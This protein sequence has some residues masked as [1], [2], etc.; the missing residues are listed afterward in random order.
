MNRIILMG[1]LGADF[2]VKAA[3]NSSVAKSRIAVRRDY[4]NAQTGEYDTDWFN[5][6]VFGKRAETAAQYFHKGQRILIEGKLRANTVENNGVKTTYYDI[7]VDDFDFVE[8]RDP[9]QAQQAPQATPQPYAQ[10]PQQY[11]PQ[12]YAQAP[13]AAPQ[14]APQQAPQQYS[15]AQNQYAPQTAPQQYTQAPQQ[16]APQPYA[17]APQAAPQQAPQQAPQAAPAPNPAQGFAPVADNN[18]GYSIPDFSG[19]ELPFN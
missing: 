11:A 14:P 19:D 18:A 2:E 16:Y 3:G 4:K 6:S 1:T 15:P 10:A 8:K 17:Q 13:Q 7:N 5:I 9:N 12:P